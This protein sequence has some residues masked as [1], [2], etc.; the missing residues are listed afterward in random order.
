MDPADCFMAIIENSN[1]I[2]HSAETVCRLYEVGR[3]KEDDEQDDDEDEEDNVR[4]C[5]L[6]IYYEI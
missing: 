6:R 2:T 5:K 3:C 4:K 1:S